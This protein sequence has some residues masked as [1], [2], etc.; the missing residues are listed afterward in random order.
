MEE[1]KRDVDMQ[2]TPDL[3]D[4]IGKMKTDIKVIRMELAEIRAA[5]F[6]LAKEMKLLHEENKKHHTDMVSGIV[7]C[8]QAFYKCKIGYE[9]VA[10]AY[11]NI[12]DGID[13]AAGI[14]SERN[15]YSQSY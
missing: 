2:D 3:G 10:E 4:D 5:F 11:E 15:L 14:I 8:R 7:A 12:E 1:E 13:S 6:N 9:R